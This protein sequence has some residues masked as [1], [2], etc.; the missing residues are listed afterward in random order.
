MH[1]V[2]FEFAFEFT[3]HGRRYRSDPATVTAHPVADPEQTDPN[4]SVNSGRSTL[5]GRTD[6]I[7]GE[8]RRPDPIG[9]L[10]TLNRGRT[11]SV[12]STV[13]PSGSDFALRKGL[14]FWELTFDSRHADIKHERG[15]FYVAWLLTHRPPHPIHAL[16]LISKIPEIYRHQ[17]GLTHITD[18]G[19]GKQATLESGA[20][21]Q[22]R[23]LSLDDA[24]SLRALFRKQKELEAIL[25]DESESEPAKHEALLELE[26]IAEFLKQ[27]GRRTQTNAQRAADSVRKSITRFHHHL[28]GAKDAD[29][30]PHPVLVPFAD[31]IEKCILIPSRRYHG[32]RFARSGLAG[33]FAYEAPANVL[34]RS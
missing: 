5:T 1:P 21:F 20:R 26:A 10:S 9:E 22:E 30:N 27:Y 11:G 15:I 14:G 12:L 28:A 17:L 16:D 6:S 23:S 18:P 33:C 19:T 34:R 24:E 7:S 32:N 2:Q 4:V 25:D 29:G 31:H 3:F 8:E 13:G